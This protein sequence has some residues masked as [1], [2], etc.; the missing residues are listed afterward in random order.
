MTLRP[1]YWILRGADTASR[2][3]EMSHHRV[4]ATNGRVDLLLADE[5][6]E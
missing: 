4:T 5:S 6:L 1:D 3:L 2:C